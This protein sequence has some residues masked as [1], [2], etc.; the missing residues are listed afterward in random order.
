MRF[1]IAAVLMLTGCGG[2]GLLVADHVDG[3]AGGAGGQ[4]GALAADAGA[5]SA[6]DVREL[7]DA[8]ETAEASLQEL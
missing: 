2:G 8:L 4:G 1:S 5:D 3:G 6:H 7:P